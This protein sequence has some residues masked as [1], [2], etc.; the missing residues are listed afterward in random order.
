MGEGQWS[1]RT[2]DTQAGGIP[3]DLLLAAF[4]ERPNEEYDDDCMSVTAMDL[5]AARR[6]PGFLDAPTP[7]S[8]TPPQPSSRKTIAA[9]DY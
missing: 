8:Q 7:S 9:G 4:G 1:T 2:R 3:A 5:E 6:V